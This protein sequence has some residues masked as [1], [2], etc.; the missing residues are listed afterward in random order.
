MTN[1]E[2]TLSKVRNNEKIGWWIGLLIV[3][4]GISMLFLPPLLG[5]DMMGIG[6]GL[7]CIGVFGSIIGI[8]TVWLFGARAGIM[9]R[10]LAGQQILA[11]WSY[12]DAKGQQQIGMEF[13]RARGRNLATYSTMFFWFVLIGGIFIAFDYLNNG[14]VSRVFIWLFFGLLGILGVIAFLTPILWRWRATNAGREV[15]ISRE[16]LVMNGT[17]HTWRSPFDRLTNINFKDEPGNPVLVFSIR[18]LSRIALVDYETVVV[19]VPADEQATA[20][21]VVNSLSRNP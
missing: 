21:L 1:K 6:Y 11:R 2:A 3:L 15:I 13:K 10:I 18:H 17:L 20:R 19:P 8:I 7:A 12:D 14:E 5:V 16:G 9:D 4:I